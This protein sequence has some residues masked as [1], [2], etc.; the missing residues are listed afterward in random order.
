M[1]KNKVGGGYGARDKA[2]QAFEGDDCTIRQPSVG[3]AEGVKGVMYKR[4]EQMQ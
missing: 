2:R 4:K 3:G 1:W